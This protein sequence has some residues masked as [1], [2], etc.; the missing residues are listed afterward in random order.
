MKSQKIIKK[1]LAVLILFG[2]VILISCSD[3]VCS[4]YSSTEQNSFVQQKN[5]DA[6]K[7]EQSIPSPYNDKHKSKLQEKF[8]AEE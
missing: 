6:K 3:K 4:A 1:T 2:S 5:K 8:A 7:S